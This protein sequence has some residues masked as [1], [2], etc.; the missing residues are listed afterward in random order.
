MS[1]VKVNSIV[2]KDGELN[3]TN[4]PCRKGDHVEATLVIRPQ[5]SEEEREAARQ[6]LIEIAKS[7]TFRS[8]GPYPSRDELHDRS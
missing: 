7:S 5:V 4:L 1:A 8:T 3:L 2:Q 6:R